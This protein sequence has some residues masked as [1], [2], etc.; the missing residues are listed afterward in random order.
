VDT[1]QQ[2]DI[3][4]RKNR[5]LFEVIQTL[6]FQM[7]VP[8]YYWERLSLLLSILSS[9]PLRVLDGLSHIGF[10]SSFFPSIR[11]L[12][13]LHSQVFGCVVFVHIHNQFCGRLDPRAIKCI[14]FVYASNKK[15]YRCYHPPSQKFFFISMDITLL[16]KLNLFTNVLSF[17][18]RVVLKLGLLNVLRHLLSLSYKNHLILLLVP[19]ILLPAHLVW[20]SLKLLLTK[21][22]LFPI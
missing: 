14:P 8:K 15:G 9:V 13:C 22:S 4:K 20:I 10:M 19:L 16:M 7:Y 6:L 17:R 21:A 5:H 11:F 1:L 12:S 18:A 2:N 3:T